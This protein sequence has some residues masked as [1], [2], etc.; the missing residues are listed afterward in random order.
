MMSGEREKRVNIVQGEFFVS[1]D[2]DV[3]I[4]TLLGSCVAACL[5]DPLARVGGMNHF[6]LPGQV[7][8]ERQ[9]AAERAGVHLMELLVNDLKMTSKLHFPSF[10]L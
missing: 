6:L 8:A 9:P 7:G 3:V 1:V 4:T 10:L 2:P 5:H